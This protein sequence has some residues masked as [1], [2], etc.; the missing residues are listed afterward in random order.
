M[1]WSKIGDVES[2]GLSLIPSSNHFHIH[3]SG[4]GMPWG[5]LGVPESCRG[6]VVC[7]AVSCGVLRD[8]SYLLLLLGQLL[9]GIQEFV[10]V[11]GIGDLKHCDAVNPSNG[12]HLDRLI[13]ALVDNRGFRQ[14]AYSLY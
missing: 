10:L 7:S 2:R 14:R 8:G 12:S 6:K 5:I 3:G 4:T 1:V 13:A 11:G 9:V